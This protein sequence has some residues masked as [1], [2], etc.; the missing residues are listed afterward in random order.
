[1]FGL[2]LPGTLYRWKGLKVRPYTHKWH[3]RLHTGTAY[4]VPR[5]NRHNFNVITSP[6]G[7]KSALVVK[8]T[9]RP[10]GV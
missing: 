7:G 2:G 8:D 1:M 9:H 6:F 4:R 10:V 5:I 3:Q